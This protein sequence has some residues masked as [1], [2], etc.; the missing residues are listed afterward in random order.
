MLLSNGPSRLFITEEPK[1]DNSSEQPFV[2]SYTSW[3]NIELL[4]INRRNEARACLVA[5]LNLQRTE[6]AHGQARISNVIEDR[7]RHARCKHLQ[8]LH[9]VAVS[10][11]SRKV[12]G[13]TCN[14]Q[15]V[16]MWYLRMRPQSCCLNSVSTAYSLLLYLAFLW[17][18]EY[19][20][21]YSWRATS[22]GT[23]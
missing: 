23:S 9:I 21:V 12:Y 15:P 14:L 1:S 22:S 17:I 4:C 6:L 2:I 7:T 5:S 3:I 10:A 16:C 8:R 11:G 19:L 13:A 18:P 20:P